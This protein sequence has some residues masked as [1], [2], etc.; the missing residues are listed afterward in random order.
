MRCGILAEM[1][2]E[3]LPT[4]DDLGQIL[5]YRSNTKLGSHLPKRKNTFGVAGLIT[6]ATLLQGAL[7][8]WSREALAERH[9]RG[10]HKAFRVAGEHHLILA[11]Q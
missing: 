1:D 6:P 2:H 4:L 9:L 10:D 5:R 8:D 3:T 7:L 11:G